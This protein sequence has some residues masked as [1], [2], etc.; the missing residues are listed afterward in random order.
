MSRTAGK[1]CVSSKE[2]GRSRLGTSLR[3]YRTCININL[4]IRTEGG[5]KRKNDIL[6]KESS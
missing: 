3:A 6:D 2:K 5:K 1:Y 4:N